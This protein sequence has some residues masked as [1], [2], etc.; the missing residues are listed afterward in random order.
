MGDLHTQCGEPQI[1]HQETWSALWTPKTVHI[2]EASVSLVAKWKQA[3]Y[4]ICLTGTEGVW[5][6]KQLL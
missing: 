1:G 4:L 3:S 5:G 2:M 6:S